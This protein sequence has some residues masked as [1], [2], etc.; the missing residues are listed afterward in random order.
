MDAPTGS[1]S[2]VLSDFGERIDTLEDAMVV[3]PADGQLGEMSSMKRHLM[4]VRKIVDPRW[5]VSA[6]PPLPDWVVEQPAVLFDRRGWSGG[7]TA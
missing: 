2:Q 6:V 7:P 5:V 3:Q 4:A 1:F